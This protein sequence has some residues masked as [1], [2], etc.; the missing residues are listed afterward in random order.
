MSCQFVD[1]KE[2][3]NGFHGVFKK[4]TYYCC[5]NFPCYVYCHSD[6]DFFKLITQWNIEGK[7]GFYKGY[8][9]L[10]TFNNPFG[11]KINLNDIPSDNK[12][13]IKLYLSCHKTQVSYIQ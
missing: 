3:Q 6:N 10:Y 1:T 4:Y 5:D 11:E 8:N 2:I 9:Y 7:R 12:F 13:K